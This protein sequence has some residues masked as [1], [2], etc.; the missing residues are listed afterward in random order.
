M[1]LRDAGGSRTHLKLLCRQPPNHPAPASMILKCPRHESHEQPSTADIES[2]ERRAV[3]SSCSSP[4]RSRTWSNSIAGCRAI[5]H[6]HGLS[7][8][9]AFNSAAALSSISEVPHR[10][11]E[12]RP[13][14]SKTV[15]LP[16]H[17]QGN[18]LLRADDWIR[19]SIIRFTKPAL[20][21]VSHVGSVR[22]RPQHEREDSN[23][24]R[25]FWR[26]TALPGARS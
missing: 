8:R 11:V 1:L 22:P 26:L 4:S 20:F 10:G 3:A 6:T 18:S 23:P 13:T 17:S 14:A 15:M 9:H 5:P 21:S 16:S 2:A 19:T 12:P 24:I 7:M 25:Q